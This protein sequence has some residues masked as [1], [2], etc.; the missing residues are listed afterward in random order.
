M[1]TAA[2]KSVQVV[3]R[4]P[5]NRNV[6]VTRLGVVGNTAVVPVALLLLL[7]QISYVPATSPARFPSQGTWEPAPLGRVSVAYSDGG[8][9][10]A[11]A[12]QRRFPGVST[13]L[14]DVWVVVPD[15]N[16]ALRRFEGND[17]HDR[18][19]RVGARDDEPR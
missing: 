1:N 8:W 3:G 12:D 5:L 11:W 9:A 4:A 15:I 14:A 2:G 16:G 13:T 17:L 18:R 6:Q 19:R 7:G 10:A